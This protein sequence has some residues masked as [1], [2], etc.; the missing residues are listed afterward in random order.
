MT[1]AELKH[2]CDF[3]FDRGYGAD[4]VAI[5][6]ADPS[7]G[8]RASEDILSISPGIDWEKGQ[9]RIQPARA[10]VSKEL[11]RDYASPVIKT[12][13]RYPD[14]TVRISIDCPSCGEHLLRRYVYCSHCGQRVDQTKY[15]EGKTY[16][17]H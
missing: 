4:E 5:T 14:G 6:T 12:T 3:L 17:I 8:A 9:I 1:L 15:Y 7:V 13:Y 2:K 16:D 11:R 10:L